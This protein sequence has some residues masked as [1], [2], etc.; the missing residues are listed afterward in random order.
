MKDK[1]EDMM[2][3]QLRRDALEYHRVPTYG[4]ISVTPTK[5]L[6]NQRDLALAYSP[7][8]AYACLAIRDDPNEAATLTSR[9][10]LVAV[11]T[12][13]TAVLGLGKYRCAGRQ[14]CDGGQGLSVQEVCRH[15][16]V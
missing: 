16:C 13:G 9:A 6:V 8:V 11:I 5:S 10:N 12:N 4:K 7:G 3:E 1:W 14:A 2:E 15:R